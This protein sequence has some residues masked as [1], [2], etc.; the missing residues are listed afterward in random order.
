MWK[1]LQRS[2]RLPLSSREQIL[3]QSRGLTKKRFLST[4]LKPATTSTNWDAFNNNN[5]PTTTLKPQGLTI[6]ILRETYDTWERRTPLTP[7]HVNELLQKEG[8][9]QV[10]VQPSPQRCFSNHEYEAAG[11]IVIE[12]LSQA[13]V[14]LGVKRPV[15][16][17]EMLADKTYLFFSH[18]IK[19]QESNMG[20]LQTILDKKI[21]LI[22]YECIVQDKA[23]KQPD[24][25]ILN[26]PE[27]L[28]AFGKYAGL[29]G[30]IDTFYPL[31]RRLVTDYGAHTPF[32]HCPPA[33]MQRDLAAAK[34]TIVRAGE[35]IVY[36]GLPPE[37]DP[38]V[39]CVTGKGGKV[40]GGAMEILE[41]LPHETISVADLP[42]LQAQVHKE[43]NKVFVVNPEPR[44]LYQHKLDGS[45]DRNAWKKN[46]GDYKSLFAETIAP[47][48][49][50]LVNCIYWDPRYARLLTKEDV[51]RLS[52]EDRNRILV[53]SDIS[54]D[55]NGS[56]ELLDRTC[57]IDKPY[58][59]YNPF[60]QKEVSPDIGDKGITVMGTDILPAELPKESS[61]HFGSAVTKVLGNILSE[62]NTSLSCMDR[63]KNCPFLSGATITADDGH[64]TD[65]YNYL[66]SF[67]HRASMAPLQ[68]KQSFDVMMNGHL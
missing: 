10:L 63:M 22:D 50:V 55:V 56:V 65:R 40:Y 62:S 5:S 33:M 66:E 44:E 57:T 29:A 45:F 13:D 67:L 30:M 1:T 61:E 2:E 34:D 27:R 36:D 48:S 51:K 31:G 59:N 16:A 23:F 20:L 49:H 15:H 9:R 52:E 37:M 46:P 32:L 41:L 54:C 39:F 8:L 21:Q 26:K 7:N 28:V 24:G 43:R 42:E 12:D 14:I 4:S 38:L 6:G 11:A 58:F 47:Y 35:K 53:V 18:V 25:S 60:L 17:E 19:G 3:H 64:L 68:A